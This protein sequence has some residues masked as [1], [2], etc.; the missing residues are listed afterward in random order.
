MVKKLLI[1]SVGS[2]EPKIKKVNP[3]GSSDPKNLSIYSLVNL[4][5]ERKIGDDK[6]DAIYLCILRL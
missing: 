2:G 5:S 4:Q 3:I 6:F 1:N